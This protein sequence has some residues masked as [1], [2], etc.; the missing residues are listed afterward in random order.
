MEQLNNIGAL[1]KVIDL[2]ISTR[3]SLGWE[4]IIQSKFY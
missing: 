4:G 3:K 2:G 1:T